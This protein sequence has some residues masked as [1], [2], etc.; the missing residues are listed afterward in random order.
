MLFFDFLRCPYIQS[1]QKK[2]F[3]KIVLRKEGDA[4]LAHR[5]AALQKIVDEGDWFFAW[6]GAHDLG[7]VLW[8]KELKSAY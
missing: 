2:D 3:A 1:S 5:A 7:E 8:K 4:N 6:S